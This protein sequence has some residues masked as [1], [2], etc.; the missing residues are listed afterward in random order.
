VCQTI[1]RRK[2]CRE[3]PS[4]PRWAIGAVL[5]PDARAAQAVE[6]VARAA[7]RVV[8]HDHW[9]AGAVSSSHLSLRRHLE[10]CRRPV[11]PA[12]PLVVRY[13]AA[14]RVAVRDIGPIR[15]TI[16][17]LILTPISVMA[18]AVP[19]D[20]AA[21]ELA[22]AFGASLLAEGCPDAGITPDIWYVNLV[23]FTGPIHDPPHLVAWIAARR[24]MEITDLQVTG[25]Q[26]VRWEYTGTGMVPMAA[27]AAAGAAGRTSTC[28]G[29]EIHV[30][31]TNI[32]ARRQ[33]GRTLP[34]RGQ[35][36]PHLGGE[37]T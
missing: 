23:Y 20:G 4:G 18:S 5:R 33:G 6:Q 14:L 2:T 19:A 37:P 8:G 34:A 1:S 28:L 11:L 32:L 10:P 3:P 22:A 7:A 31:E 15:F 30:S 35:A 12:D 25:I 24:Q 13:A 29:Y 21:D 17:G 36:A 9:L 26:I 16:N 27:G